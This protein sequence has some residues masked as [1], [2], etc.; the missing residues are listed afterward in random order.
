MHWTITR[1][2]GIS[3]V[4]LSLGTGALGGVAIATDQQVLILAM[5][6]AIAAVALAVARLLSKSII[7]PLR[8]LHHFITDAT[9]KKDFSKALK[10]TNKGELGLL[11]EDVNAM[12]G[13][14]NRLMSELHETNMGFIVGISECLESLKR[15]DRGQPAVR[16][17]GT[18]KD[19]LLSKLADVINHIAENIDYCADQS[20]EWLI[21]ISEHY[22]VLNKLAAGDR[23]IRAL[24]NSKNE[25]I[26]KMGS[27]INKMAN[28]MLSAIEEVENS[29]VE[30]AVFFSGVF[31]VLKKTSEGDLTSSVAET[32]ENEVLLRLGKVTNRTITN[33]KALIGD[34]K[35]VIFRIDSSCAEIY[36]AAEEQASG[37]AEQSSAVSEI[38]TTV[39]E[40]AATASRI[41]GSAEN[42][43]KI[44]EQTFTGMQEIHT[45][46]EQTAKKM[47]LL[48]EKSQAIGNITKLIDDIAEQTNLL[49]LNAAIEA[50]RAGEAGRGFTVV[51]QEVRKLAERTS[52]STE[53]IRQLITEI[54][55][56]TNSTIMGVEDSTKWVSKGLEMV[57]ETVRVVREIFVATQQQ[58][59]ASSQVVV[60]IKNIDS[61]TKQFVS[62]T[63]ETVSSV[64]ELSKL[65]QELRQNVEKFRLEAS[66]KK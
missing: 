18:F 1:K 66:E 8:N 65:A 56:E 4:L 13:E 58:K 55:G 43:T 22:N 30:L 40:L 19:E 21:G 38:S 64:A 62:S 52:E 53:E 34:V 51:A 24:E 54:Q 44:A 36:A 12:V 10:V 29:G 15:I 16:I 31:E 11:E 20:Q 46:V 59:S 57:K 41:A 26:A 14:V 17:Q 48:G 25:I 61:V 32:T 47:L 39:E 6:L 23:E 33:L 28:S 5:F 60:A 9:A 49:A 7:A 42:V 35:K 63:K 3:I 27:V 45:K 37:A 2:L 50:A